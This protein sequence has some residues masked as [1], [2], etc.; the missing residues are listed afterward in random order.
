MYH[1]EKDFAS[2]HTH[3]IVIMSLVFAGCS[4]RR[5]LWLYFLCGIPKYLYLLL[6]M[7]IHFLLE[8]CFPFI[9]FLVI[10]VCMTG[11]GVECMRPDRFFMC[12]IVCQLCHGVEI[13][14]RWIFFFFRRVCV[15][16]VN[17]NWKVLLKRCTKDWGSWPK[18]RVVGLLCCDEGLLQRIY[19]TMH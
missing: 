15:V 2:G 12:C 17:G 18:L 13:E 16:W 11:F 10:T 4:Q 1:F 14:L 7:Y 8:A 19:I 9:F 3:F 6:S 5:K